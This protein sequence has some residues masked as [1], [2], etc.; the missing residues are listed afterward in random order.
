VATAAAL[1]A[2]AAMP[3]LAAA[4][5]NRAGSS[6]SKLFFGTA[7]EQDISSFTVEASEPTTAGKKQKCLKN[8]SEV[9]T[10]MIRT[11]WHTMVGTGG[12]VTLTAGPGNQFGLDTVLAIYKSGGSTPL[13]C[14]DDVSASDHTSAIYALPTTAGEIYEVQVGTPEGVECF[15]ACVVSLLA[16]NDQSPPG[17]Q[18]TAP[19]PVVSAA[20][21]DNTYAA[22]EPGEVLACKFEG[23]THEYF[24]T[25]WFDYRP[26]EYGTATIRT[27]GSVDT[28]AAIYEGASST[29]FACNDDEVKGKIYTSVLTVPTAPG[30][31]Y[32]LQV[33]G[34]L[35]E[36][37]PFGVAVDF[38]PNKDVDGDGAEATRFGGGDCNDSDPM[39]RPGAIEIPGNSVDENCDGVVAPFPR[40]NPKI[41]T[42]F[43]VGKSTTRPTKLVISGLPPGATVKLNCQGKK[44]KGCSFKSKSF[45]VRS[46]AKLKLTSSVKGLALKP[47]AALEVRATA[48]ETIGSDV[49]YQIRKGKQPARSTLCLP[50]G[51]SSPK[52]C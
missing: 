35:S 2:L 47:G 40:L 27:I 15:F 13:A 24:R 45:P 43:D 14:S 18:R 25:I 8:G 46:T 10:G 37:G 9:E 16:T 20:N 29:P 44:K 41:A 6:S 50:P 26:T 4:S 49:S 30:Q 34:Y 21:A 19:L 5:D 28:I 17:D 3:A 36:R 11:S 31:D 12:T 23:S 52:A 39:I 38:A 22:E 33:G 1:A 51:A 48:A 42:A 32:Q 7:A